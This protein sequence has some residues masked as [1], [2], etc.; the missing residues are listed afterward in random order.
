[1]HR[2]HSWLPLLSLALAAC[3]QP[4]DE[5]IH[6]ALHVAY[7]HDD[8]HD[9]E[10]QF[11]LRD[12]E[13]DEHLLDLSSLQ[14]GREQVEAI[15]GEARER[16]VSLTIAT[17][18]EL[19]WHVTDIALDELQS[20]TAAIIGP[21]TGARKHAVVLCRF[22][23][24]P[25]P[26]PLQTYVDLWGEG[27]HGMSA[28]F[29][30]Q[31]YG[32]MSVE[33]TQVAGWYTMPRTF[34]GYLLSNGKPD[35]EAIRRDCTKLAQS[36][37]NFPS[38]S[39]IVVTTNATAAGSYSTE[40]YF[41][42]NGLMKVYSFVYLSSFGGTSHSEIA[43][44][45]GHT[46]GLDHSARDSYCGVGGGAGFDYSNVYTPMGS[47]GPPRHYNSYEKNSIGWIPSAKRTV[48]SSPANGSVYLDRWAA[49]YT[50]TQRLMAQVPIPSSSSY[51]TLEYRHR[52]IFDVSPAE[53]VVVH[54]VYPGSYPPSRIMA[55]ERS[56]TATDEQLALNVGERFDDH[57]SGVRIAVEQEDG[58]GA[59]VRVSTLPVWP[60]TL[61][62]SGFG[63]MVMTPGAKGTASGTSTPYTV[64]AGTLAT[65]TATPD[66]GW[67]FAGWS[68][69]PTPSGATCYALADR[70]RTITA[71]FVA[72]C[73]LDTTCFDACVS[74][75]FGDGFSITTCRTRCD[76]PCRTCP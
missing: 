2:T 50:T 64:I 7:M 66:A 72:S 59:Q 55:P 15:L 38:F 37:I 26:A 53:G 34:A 8:N 65:I 73:G 10:R 71:T 58:I 29:R 63:T 9:E 67:T 56:C 70:A 35:A 45:V 16:S 12:D 22:T 51:Y 54:K 40:S 48:F 52:S 19:Q 20:R 44:E 76:A 11:L 28:Y 33:G 1:M 75:C 62:R 39:S 18:D 31:S 42:L 32:A 60:I 27:S 3:G 25:N 36:S 24:L 6:G 4:P 61:A 47:V 13:G 5:R 21:K 43:H 74:D 49:P 68:N 69:C 41:T 46:L 30:E 17:G 23:D 14:G 57:I